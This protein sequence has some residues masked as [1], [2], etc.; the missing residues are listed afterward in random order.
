MGRR[1]RHTVPG[2]I[3]PRCGSCA[4]AEKDLQS[5]DCVTWRGGS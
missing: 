2:S 4:V 1:G 3:Q 5:T